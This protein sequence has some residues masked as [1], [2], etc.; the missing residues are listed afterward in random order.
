[1]RLSSSQ[2]RRVLELDDD[3]EL[4]RDGVR[5]AF[6]K[7]ALKVHPDKNPGCASPCAVSQRGRGNN[8]RE[9]DI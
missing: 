5:A 6:R 2:A 9:G 1:M 8:I 3:V 7:L 4:T